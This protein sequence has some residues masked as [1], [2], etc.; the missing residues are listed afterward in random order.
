MP[1]I[2]IKT[3]IRN[4]IKHKTYSIINIL[5]LATGIA[6]FLIIY[7]YVSDE[8]SYDRYHSKA[9]DIYRLVNVYDFEGVGEKNASSPFPVA[10]TLKNE[11]PNLISNATRIFNFQAP[12]SFI[13]YQDKKFNERRFYFADSTFF[14]IFDY[15]FIKG[16]PNTALDENGSVI[17]TE[18]AAKKY[19]GSEDPMGKTI[20]FETRLEMHITGI[21]ED[22]PQQSHF[23]FDFIGSMSTLREQFGGSLPRTWIWNPCWTYIV[24]N[25][26]IDPSTLEKQ[27]PDFIQKY[28]YDAEKNNVTLYLQ[29]LTDIH[30]KSKLDYE[31]EP[32]SDI[33]SVYIFSVIAVFLLLIAVINYMNLAT[34]TSASRAKEIGIKKVNGA[35]RIHLVSQFLS[36]S[37]ILCFIALV[38]ALII[39]EFALPVFNDLTGKSIALNAVFGWQN[40]IL[41]ILLGLF[42]GFLS[43]IYPS[44]YLASFQP[45]TVL[46]SKL[47][48]GTASGLP[49]KILVVFQFSISIMLIIGTLVIRKQL[50]FMRNSDL[51]FNKENI[52]V[53][54]VNR[55]PVAN[56]FLTFKRELLNNPNIVSVTS[57]DDI[58]GASHNTH[59]FRP[60]GF[61]EDKWQFYPALVVNYDFL[62]TFGIKLIAG[63]DYQEENKTDPSNGILINE[64]MIKHLGWETSGNAP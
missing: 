55:T 43:G 2:Y 44:C 30:L 38:F 63:R 22:V 23:K 32:N 3:T 48:T 19:F 5:G 64:S 45:I 62:K 1:L 53:I 49:R 7:L 47:R 26:N 36:E 33:S 60:E 21:I 25:K 6:S 11:F 24:L 9:E 39:A 51:G 10:F 52:I 58:F 4:L 56:D 57:M 46:K 12:R 40:L 41:I 20:R 29:A 50:D 13:E 35:D 27:F 31:I 16:N 37:I 34:A 8:I 42:I 18:S 61:P 54:P 28:F 59:E 17:L 14:E 15:K